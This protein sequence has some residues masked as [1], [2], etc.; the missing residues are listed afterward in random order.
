MEPFSQTT[1]GRLLLVAS[2]IA[3]L[4]GASYVLAGSLMA[5]AIGFPIAVAMSLVAAGL[6]IGEHAVQALIIVTLGPIALFLF[7]VGVG[8]SAESH[9]AWAYAFGVLGVAALVASV[10]GRSDARAHGGA[11]VAPALRKEGSR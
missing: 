8:V 7:A 9:H 1:P 2:A 4:A 6:S 5:L 10:R 3:L 11:E